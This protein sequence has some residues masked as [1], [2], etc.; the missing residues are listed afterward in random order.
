MTR[1]RC[2]CLRFVYVMTVILAVIVSCSVIVDCSEA[3]VAQPDGGHDGWA[4]PSPRGGTVHHMCPDPEPECSR[5]PGA[6]PPPPAPPATPHHR[7]IGR[8]W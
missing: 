4:P 2:S 5:H 7:K 8:S 1:K 3:D 6:P